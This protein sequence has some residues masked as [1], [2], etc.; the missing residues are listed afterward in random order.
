M[1]KR[2]SDAFDFD[3][4]RDEYDWLFEFES[5]MAAHCGTHDVPNLVAYM[6]KLERENTKLRELVQGIWRACPVYEDD[7]KRCQHFVGDDDWCDF[8][9]TMRELGAEVDE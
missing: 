3:E 9:Q 7:C 5:R 2:P 6:N 4:L 1:S 8:V